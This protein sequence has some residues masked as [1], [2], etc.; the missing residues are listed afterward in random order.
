MAVNDLRCI[1]LCHCVLSDLLGS[2]QGDDLTLSLLALAQNSNS[3]ESMVAESK[4][5]RCQV[6]QNE[7]A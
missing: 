4:H 1:Q 3:V 7:A 5:R 6:L 2:S